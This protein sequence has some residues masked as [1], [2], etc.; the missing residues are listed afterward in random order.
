MIRPFLASSSMSFLRFL[1]ADISQIMSM[2][3]SPAA[4]CHTMQHYTYHFI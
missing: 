4:S 2:P 1:D 3:W